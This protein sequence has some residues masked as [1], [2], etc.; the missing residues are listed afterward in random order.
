MEIKVGSPHHSCIRI[1]LLAEKYIKRYTSEAYCHMLIM[2]HVV[3]PSSTTTLL[4]HAYY[5]PCSNSV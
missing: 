3:T 4:S 1:S 2:N 5:E